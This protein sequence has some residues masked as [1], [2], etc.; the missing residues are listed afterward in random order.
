MTDNASRRGAPVTLLA[1]LALAA[2]S[3]LAGLP[4]IAAA[5][6]AQPLL[7]MGVAEM[8][9]PEPG[10][11]L[12][13][14]CRRDLPGLLALWLGAPLL[15][16]ALTAWPL[17]SLHRH[18][19]LGA[20]LLLSTAVAVM[21]LLLWR[22]WP[23]WHALE[24]E[25]GP[26][27]RCRRQL[28]RVDWQQGRGLAAVAAL[29]STSVMSF[30]PALP[31]VPGM[32]VMSL[33]VLGGIGAGMAV[34]SVLMHLVLQGLRIEED[35]GVPVA[36]GASGQ[37]PIAPND[38]DL[39]LAE[40]LLAEAARPQPPLEPMGPNQ[41][42]P[43]LYEAARAGRVER[44]L[45]LIDAGADVHALPEADA[46]DQRQLGVLAAVLPDLRLLRTLIAHGL[47]I[48]RSHR[49]ITPLLAATRDSWHGRPEAVVTLIANGADVL[50]CDAEGNTPLHFAARSADPGV[51]AQLRDAGA[52]INA[53]N[54]E[55]YTPLGI[56][57]LCGNWRLARYLL[58][59]G[60]RTDVE[61][62]V[63]ALVAAA[64]S[65]D[66]DPVGVQLLLRHKAKVSARDRQR[67]TGLH[68]AAAAGHVAVVEVLLGAGAPLEARDLAGRTPFLEACA[69]GRTAVLETLLPHL[70]DLH[71]LDGL[72]R[73]AIW[74]AAAADQDA[75]ILVRQLLTLGVGGSV[76]DTEG[77]RAVDVAA[78][79]GRWAVVAMLDPHRPLPAAVS[80]ALGTPDGD[81][82]ALANLP[83]RPPL[84][85]L[86]ETLGRGSTDAMLDMA[87]LCTADELG[88]LLHDAQIQQHP[89]ALAWLLA[90]GANA[91]QPDEAGRTAAFVLLG[92]GRAGWPALQ[93]FLDRDVSLAGE[94]GL[95]R[96]L[97]A[98]LADPVHAR[99]AEFSVMDLLRRDLD[100]VTASTAGDPPLSL[101]VRL[102]WLS[103][104]A[105]LLVA[106]AD[107]EARDSQRLT[108]L[109]L[110]TTLGREDAVRLLVQQGADPQ[111]RAADGQTPLGVALSLGRQDLAEWLDW[112]IWPLPLRR[113]EEA[114]LPSAAALGDAEAVRRLLSL[115]LIVDAVDAQGCTALLRAAGAGHLDLVQTLLERGADPCK[116]ASSGVI[117]LSA[118]VT[119]RQAAIVDALIGAGADVEQRLPGKVSVLMLAATL[120]MP[121]IVA[122]LL[123][124]GADVQA[125]DAK[126]LTALHCAAQFGYTAR[127]RNRL[128]ALFDGL[129][130]AGA[131][132]NAV[133]AMELSP[134]LLLLGAGADPGTPCDVTV[135][136]AG[137]DRLLD[138]GA[139]LD[140]RDARGFG[141]L[142][143]AALHGQALLVQRLLRAGA[144]PA[145][146]DA[147]GRTPRDIAVMRG[148]IDIAVEF[149][150]RGPGVSSLGRFQRQDG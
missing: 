109:H 55:G 46:R 17:L 13:A 35:S 52:D 132:V 31:F 45:Q 100:T 68:E 93:V 69:H 72:G 95:A 76:A 53:L 29:L 118:A 147:L 119:M 128:L 103:L 23:M 79:A 104:S 142:H 144:D 47:D 73:N 65:E 38:A 124:G 43:E 129:L 24:R 121:D 62:A 82:A 70:P 66:D 71:A 81:V 89:Q 150:P 3:V 50:A 96:V 92:A 61:G 4:G 10:I 34:L 98:A 9:V 146:Q 113:F 25:G 88:Q 117:P 120:G 32:P 141:V 18:G 122:R 78:S 44:A 8:R 28:A 102:D 64:G 99:L 41:W 143:L 6:A 85:L 106:G 27:A 133:A 59:R 1:G 139:S 63:P 37:T 2:G 19:S 112:R 114:D 75:A 111:A 11:G 145:M 116:A 84:A 90:H 148:Y 140:A 130:L 131:E 94:G 15:L 22:S 115:G 127:D 60:A 21:A 87:R 16:A 51:A 57:C 14:R 83:D 33:P 58:E 42:G 97:E 30:L 135:V 67:R 7:A 86:R 5:V 56:A 123:A 39:P 36:A 74:L 20:A 54:A 101:A 134:L 105:A 49:G 77:R 126:G 138:E 136:V 26:W 40:Q 125:V 48:N 137:I 108:A 80:D 107:R 91:D 149:E 12:L 110:A